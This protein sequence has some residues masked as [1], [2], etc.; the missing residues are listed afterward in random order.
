[1]G[2]FLITGGCGFFGTWI[3]RRLLADGH[4]VSVID[5]ARTTQRWEMVL[6]PAQIESIGFHTIGIDDAEAVK[7]TFLEVKPDAV[8]HL[9]ALQ[10]PTCRADPLLGARVNVIGTIAIFEAA[11]ALPNKPP[12][13][14]A[15][16]AAVFGSDADYDSQP[17][18]DLSVPMPGTIYGAFKLCNEHCAR[19]YW[20]DHQVT[21]V[22]FR[23]YTVYGPGRNVG[24]TS[25]PTRAIAAA[26]LG[27]AFDIPFSGPCPYTYAEEVAD[28][29]AEAAMRPHPGAASYTMG[30]D[31][32]DVPRFIDELEAVLPGA[33]QRITCS[34]GDLPITAKLDDQPLRRAYPNVQHVRLADG[35]RRTVDIF[36]SLAAKGKLEV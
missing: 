17:V 10:V 11:K 31:T 35:I 32:V 30:G 25:F 6:S 4:R 14:Y 29:F 13:V 36:R 9:A 22:G 21:S 20:Q 24:I 2:H 15:S 23:P 18:G 16:S 12:I 33:K 1:M 8:I 7:K 5:A 28:F 34:G 26:V 27:R 19:V 3:I